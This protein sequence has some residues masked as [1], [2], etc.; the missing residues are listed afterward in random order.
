MKKSAL[1]FTATIALLSSAALAAPPKA[2]QTIPGAKQLFHEA[3][4]LI[5]KEYVD[6]KLT[7]DQLWTLALQGVLSGLIQDE[8]G[9]VN[10][11]IS[12]EELARLQS[13]LR[14]K[15]SGA[16]L[17][18]HAVE[19]MF[20]VRAVLAEGPA[21]QTNI[22]PGDRIL[23]V[24]N[25]PAK[26]K[27]LAQIVG[28]IRGPTGTT[29]DLVVQRDRDEWTVP[30]TRGSITL[31]SVVSAELPQNIGYVKIS[32]FSKNTETQLQTHLAKLNQRA[33][34][35]LDLRD[36][37]GGLLDIALKSAEHFLAPGETIISSLGRN[38]KKSVRAASAKS[39]AYEQPI[40]ILIGKRTASS[41]EIL[42]AALAENKRALL[43]GERTYGKSTA[44]SIKKLSKGWALK[45][46][47]AKFYSP[48]G[49]SWQTQGLQPNFHIPDDR[50]EDR[51]Y[52]SKPQ[53]DPDKDAQLRAGL[54][55]LALELR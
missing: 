46:S 9:H 26:G 52:T 42:A 54:S 14:G 1:L 35:V 16:G 33:G 53:V 23:A 7:E 39:R 31:Q 21:G 29:V 49:N 27:T 18:I 40:V 11:M 36:C 13:D 8:G 24:N 28:L 50:P 4:A 48:L 37:P 41:G 51:Y 5:E 45:L 43:V 55:V 12:P 19:E 17:V 15:I 10:R 22:Q 44:E 25:Q 6:E 34:L 3:L 20:I 2:P 38:G 32:N 47:I 30:I